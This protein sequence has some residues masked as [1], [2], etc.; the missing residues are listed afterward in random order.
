MKT[1]LRLFSDRLFSPKDQPPTVSAETA[2]VLATRTNTRLAKADQALSLALPRLDQATDYH[3]MSAG[4]WALHD[5]VRHFAKQT[6]PVEC[7]G[8]TWS[9][10]MPAV[11]MLVWMRKDGALTGLQM[12]VDCQMS[13]WSVEA[14]NYLATNAER[15]YKTGIHAKGFLLS[16]ETWKVS[17]IASAN[18]SNNPRLEAYS[19]S[20]APEVFDFHRK[21]YDELIADLHPFKAEDTPP[22]I[23]RNSATGPGQPPA[24]RGDLVMVRGLPGSGKSTAARVIAGP[25]GA[26]IEADQ[27]FTKP[28]GRYE[29]IEDGFPLAHAWCQAETDAALTDGKT[30]VVVAN[31]SP[32]R[33]DLEPYRRL[34]AQHGYRFTCLV[35][36][37]RHG[38]QN[39]H[40]VTVQ[41]I[42]KIKG[43]FEVQL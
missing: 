41:T 19:I 6:G 42:G 33:A 3:V 11:E 15:V 12:V 28:D 39:I 43:K 27:F 22:N 20:T 21:W 23:E 18:F 31:I 5:V 24:F 8:F 29:V 32:D 34:A 40:G 16:N 7:R 4:S 2:V 30:P 10:T 1:Q 25:A 38:G 26:V 17:V 14:S 35:A 36:E 13:K 37:N 9:L